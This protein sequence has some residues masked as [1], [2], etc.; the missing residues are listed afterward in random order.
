LWLM[1]QPEYLCGDYDT[2][3]LDQLLADAASTSDETQSRRIYNELSEREEEIVAIA[4]ALDA[5]MRAS[6]RRGT[7]PPAAGTR[8]TQAARRGALRG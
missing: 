4:A 3:Y 2:T 6:T 8:W 7:P 1:R 5:Y